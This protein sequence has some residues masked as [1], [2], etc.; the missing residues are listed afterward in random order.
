MYSSGFTTPSLTSTAVIPGLPLG[1]LCFKSDPHQE[2]QIIRAV[3]S[4]FDQL[5][6]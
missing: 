4:F 5:S 3:S 6:I 2:S 1:Y